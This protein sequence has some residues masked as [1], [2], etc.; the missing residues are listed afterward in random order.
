MTSLT[1]THTED[2]LKVSTDAH[3]LVQ[4]GR[5]GQIGT[6]FK[7]RHREDICSTFAGSWKGTKTT[8]RQ[9]M[10]FSKTQTAQNDNKLQASKFPYLKVSPDA[11]ITL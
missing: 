2:L 6:G 5:L 11:V 3:L 9:K 7:V 10:L 8:F 1:W 4:L